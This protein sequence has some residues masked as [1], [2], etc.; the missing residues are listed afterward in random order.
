VVETKSTIRTRRFL[1]EI[2]LVPGANDETMLFSA[3]RP[4]LRPSQ[5]GRAHIGQVRSPPSGPGTCEP[6]RVTR[7]FGILRLT[8]LAGGSLRTRR[9]GRNRPGEHGQLEGAG[10]G[11]LTRFTV[12]AATAFSLRPVAI[13]ALLPLAP[14]SLRSFALPGQE[15]LGSDVPDPRSPMYGRM[16]IRRVLP[17]VEAGLEGEVL[18]GVDTVE[19]EVEAARRPLKPAGKTGTNWPGRPWQGLSALPGPPRPWW[20]SP[21]G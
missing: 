5:G 21:A 15:D 1:I 16:L 9:V 18:I 2:P 6:P 20:R 3:D 4:R 19:V 11:A 17:V 13:L 12:L 14:P 10:S 7:Y 8:A